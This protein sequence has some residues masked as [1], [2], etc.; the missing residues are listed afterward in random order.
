MTNK[1]LVEKYLA[2]RG[3]RLVSGSTLEPLLPF[4]IM[5][6]Q[7]QLYSH[8]VAPLPVKRE[9]K[10]ERN[11]WIA[12]YN[13]FNKGLFRAFD[14][15][16]QDEIIDKMDEFSAYIQNDLMI[17]KVA[18]MD[19]VKHLPFERQNVIG[20]CLMC[21][22]LAQVAQI[23]W[24]KVFHD[25]HGNPETNRELHCV[26]ISSYRFLN[27]YHHEGRNISCNTE[28]VNTALDIFCRKA[29]KWLYLNE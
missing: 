12:A 29:V 25:R 28:T 4:I 27:M 20:S 13:K 15:D 23:I 11:K 5:D 14:T 2:S 18:M 22:T 1:E 3:M 21:N 7:Y 19:L 8:D 24:S 26:R 17:T 6:A 10:Q 16:E 9:M